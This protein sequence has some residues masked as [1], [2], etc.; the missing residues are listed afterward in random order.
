MEARKARPLAEI[1]GG[2]YQCDGTHMTQSSAETMMTVMREGLE[3]AG[4]R[5]DE[6]D[7]VNAH[8]TATVHG[9][10]EEARAISGVFGP[11][12]AVSSLKG[13]LGHSLAACGALE[14]IAAVQMIQNSLLIPTR[15][16]EEVAP[17]CRGVRHLTANTP[18][19]VRNILSNNFAFGGMNTCLLVSRV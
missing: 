1:R 15:N 9:D 5:A 4:L 13:H 7:Y 12:I 10:G 8:A 11:G 2:T 14:A 3:R 19:T 6:I 18:M 16:L 17:E